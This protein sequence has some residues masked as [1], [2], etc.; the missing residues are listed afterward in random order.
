M[1]FFFEGKPSLFSLCLVTGLHKLIMF[2]YQ[3]YVLYRYTTLTP[4]F[5]IIIGPKKKNEKKNLRE[6]RIIFDMLCLGHKTF[7]VFLRSLFFARVKETFNDC[8]RNIRCLNTMS[9]EKCSIFKLQFV[10]WETRFRKTFQSSSVWQIYGYAVHNKLC[11]GTYNNMARRIWA[12]PS[13]V[14]IFHI[15]EQFKSLR[16]SRMSD[17]SENNRHIW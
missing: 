10:K 13:P 4:M 12:I 5:L 9:F 7:Y 15:V 8:K 11:I 1:K 2:C 3:W 17:I 6:N 16:N 14:G